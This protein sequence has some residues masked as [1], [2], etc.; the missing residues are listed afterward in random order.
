ML[1]KPKVWWHDASQHELY[2][3]EKEVKMRTLITVENVESAAGFGLTDVQVW[4][5]RVYA[6]TLDKEENKPGR[7]FEIEE[8]ILI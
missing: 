8:L 1:L 6:W 5:A 2:S 3:L 4:Y 7:L